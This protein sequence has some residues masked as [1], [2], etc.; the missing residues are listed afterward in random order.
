MSNAVLLWEGFAPPWAFTTDLSPRISP[1]QSTYAEQHLSAPTTVA[2][3][4][5]KETFSRVRVVVASCEVIVELARLDALG[6]VAWRRVDE[7][8]FDK[9]DDEYSP[10]TGELVERRLLRWALRALRGAHVEETRR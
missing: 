4:I 5:G 7:L 3:P 9:R 10:P 2:L 8:E 6:G 1:S